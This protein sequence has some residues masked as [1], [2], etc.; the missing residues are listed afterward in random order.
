MA[1]PLQHTIGMEKPFPGFTPTGNT[2]EERV[3]HM[4]A[5]FD[6]VKGMRLKSVIIVHEWDEN[7]IATYTEYHNVNVKQA[8]EIASQ[9]TNHEDLY[10]YMV[11]SMTCSDKLISVMYCCSCPLHDEIH[12]QNYALYH[13]T[14]EDLYADY[15]NSLEEI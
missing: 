11:E 10:K 5:E 14:L 7:R 12:Y 8:Y 13:H 4:K 1:L 3:K 15:E 2:R 6:K 9:Y